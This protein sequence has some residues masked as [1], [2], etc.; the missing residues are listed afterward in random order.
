MS[1]LRILLVDD[2]GAMRKIEKMSLKKL[3]FTDVSEAVDGKD[4]LEKITATKPDLVLCDWNMPE[5]QKMLIN[6]V[7]YLIAE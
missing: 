1:E 7:D 3:G 2:S 5:F 4:G 6:A